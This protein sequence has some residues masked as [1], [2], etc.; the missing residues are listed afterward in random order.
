MA[1][2]DVDLR[3]DEKKLKQFGF[4][5]L[6]AFALLGGF[7]LWRGGL[8]GIDFGASAPPI[9][10]VLFA[11]GGLSAVLSFV[12]PA[13]N[14]VLYLTLV[15]VTIPIGIVL[16]FVIVGGLFYGLF[17]P[18]GLFFRLIGRDPLNLKFDPAAETYWTRRRSGDIDPRNYFRQY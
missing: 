10:Y 18:I 1:L 12:M 16:S 3:P 9:A 7:L 2:V 17:T 6:V 8:F 14:K 5:A 15:V 4:V 13:A 11:L